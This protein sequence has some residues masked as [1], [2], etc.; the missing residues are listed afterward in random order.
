MSP[1]FFTL[2]SAALF[3]LVFLAPLAPG[4][5]E[6]YHSRD[7]ERLAVEQSYLREP[8][9]FGTAFVAKVQPFVD[10][11]PERELRRRFLRRRGEHARIARAISVERGARERDVLIAL[12]RITCRPNARLTD[13]FSAGSLSL[14]EG[15]RARVAC[16]RGPLRLAARCTIDRW[17]DAEGDAEIGESC[18]L[19]AAATSNGTL[20]LGSDCRFKR[21]FGLPIV[22]TPVTYATTEP[23]EFD[24]ELWAVGDRIER[25]NLRIGS[26]A[27]IAGNVKTDGLLVVEPHSHV[28]GNLICR[29]GVRIGRASS[30]E[31]HVFCEGDATIEDGVTIG[32]AQE[33]TTVYC[34][35]TL[36]I[37]RGVTIYGNVVADG[38][39][40]IG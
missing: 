36:A 3:A 28:N 29:S 33:H 18:T 10:E 4:L 14:G 20:Q 26:G 31:G 17:I 37:G 32:S 39:G 13:L 6:I 8:R 23:V 30:I 35:G 27:T 24:E 9:Y 21:L 15:C 38:G 11:A 25:D 19:G 40:R 1:L 16:S 34:A 22:T 12:E 5:W 7:D 2:A